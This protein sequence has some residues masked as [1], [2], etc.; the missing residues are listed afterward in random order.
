LDQTGIEVMKVQ[1][2]PLV[3]EQKTIFEPKI[4]LT[5][6]HPE[7]YTVLSN[8]PIHELYKDHM[9][10]DRI[11]TKFD[12]TSMSP[13]HILIMLTT[14]TGV[15]SE[16]ENF[17]IWCRQSARQHVY[18][19]INVVEKVMFYFKEIYL[20]ELSKLDIVAFWHSHDNN[21]ATMGQVLQ[22]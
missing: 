6:Q 1:L 14:F 3:D 2:F 11:W 22:R 21:Y 9:D 5:V 16:F 13:Q 12:E 10:M 8:I 20:W 19:A 15:S 18:Y 7:N 17:T 4:N